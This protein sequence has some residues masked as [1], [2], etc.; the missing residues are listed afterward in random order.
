MSLLVAP[1]IELGETGDVGRRSGM[2]MSVLASGALTGP[3]ISGA[4]N[5]ATNGYAAVGVYAGKLNQVC[6]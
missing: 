1:M 4:I 3:P 5:S 6:H 2:F